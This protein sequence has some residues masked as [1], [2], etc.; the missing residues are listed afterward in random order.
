MNHYFLHG[1]L[2]AKAGQA[3]QLSNILLQAA[4]L[5]STAKGCKLYVIGRDPE[6]TKAVWV[7][8]IWES[9]ADHDN[10]LHVEGVKELI[11][12]AMPILDGPPQK[13]QELEILGGAGI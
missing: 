11:S 4:E 9:K 8:E 10:S 6:D 5:V 13:G 2:T 7:T 1:K 12:K 3:E